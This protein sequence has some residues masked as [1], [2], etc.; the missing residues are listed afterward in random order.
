MTVSQARHDIFP[1]AMVS[2]GEDVSIVSFSSKNALQQKLQ[3]LGLMVGS[4]VKVLKNDLGSALLLAVGD[5]RIA[6]GHGMA[7][8]IM[9][10]TQA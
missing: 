4:H 1:L 7:H 10:Q 8:K 2:V 6:L 5:T 9:I 3:D